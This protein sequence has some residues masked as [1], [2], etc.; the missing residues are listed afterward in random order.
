M[1][2]FLGFFYVFI[3]SFKQISRLDLSLLLSALGM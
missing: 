1:L 2:L 3:V